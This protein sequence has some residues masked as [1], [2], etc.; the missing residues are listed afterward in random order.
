MVYTRNYLAVVGLS[1]SFFVYSYNVTS[2][3][4]YN[5]SSMCQEELSIEILSREVCLLNGNQTIQ[6]NETQPENVPVVSSHTVNGYGL[7]DIV[8]GVM[9]GTAFGV[10]GS[11][12]FQEYMTKN[13]VQVKIENFIKDLQTHR[14]LLQSTYEAESELCDSACISIRKITVPE[15]KRLTVAHM[16]ELY[17]STDDKSIHPSIVDKITD[18]CNRVPLAEYKYAPSWNGIRAYLRDML[19]RGHELRYCES[20]SNT[21]GVRFDSAGYSGVAVPNGSSIGL[22]QAYVNYPQEA[23]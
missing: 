19:I 8:L 12:L 2:E 17:F 4:T 16:F 10:L 11:M 3:I 13:P 1:L 15:I 7:Q 5:D 9:G 20:I 22:Y 23:R 21:N 18:E 6:K 14:K